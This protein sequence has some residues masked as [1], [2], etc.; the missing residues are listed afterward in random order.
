MN[1]PLTLTLLV[2]ARVLTPPEHTLL[3]QAVAPQLLNRVTGKVPPTVGRAEGHGLARARDRIK[4]VSQ[5]LARPHK[6]PTATR[7]LHVSVSSQ[8]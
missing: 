1:K 4:A 6:T 3:A 8:I 5:A 7:T 2:A